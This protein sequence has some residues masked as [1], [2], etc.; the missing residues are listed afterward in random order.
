[1]KAFDFSQNWWQFVV[2]AVVCYFVGCFN[3]A[4]LISKIKKRDI[5]KIGSGNPGTMNMSREFGLKV[6]LITFLCDAV[7]GGSLAL[8]S[9][10]IYRDYYFEDSFVRV[11]DVTRY[12]CGLCVIIGHIFPV[13]MKFKGGKGIASTL[14]LFWFCL[15]CEWGWWALICFGL[16]VGVVFFIAYTEWGSLGSLLGVSG[17]SII[18][19]VIF[20]KRYGNVFNAYL[21]WLYMLILAINVLTWVA[22]HQNIARL[23]SG[24]EH[25]TSVKKLAKKKVK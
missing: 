22:H 14:G 8:I 2:I 6:G 1:M 15:P 17:L 4:R 23:F 13:T 19:L 16:L 11:S 25:H 18:Q 20:F 3:F 12:F 24:E 7:K 9:Y 5:T 10:F 21:V